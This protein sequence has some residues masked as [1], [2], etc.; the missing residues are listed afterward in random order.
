MVIELEGIG[1]TYPG[2][3][4]PVQA[5]QDVNLQVRAGEVLGVIGR[6]GAG[7]SSLVRVI[8]LLR[9]IKACDETDGY[10]SNRSPFC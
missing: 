1:L 5:L 2:H 3:P 8:N 9:H 7:K 10:K 4:A 6:S